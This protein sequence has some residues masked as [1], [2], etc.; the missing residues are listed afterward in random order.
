MQAD[1][2]LSEPPEKPKNTGVG[3][4]PLL[5]G[6]FPIQES[7]QGLQHCRWI[8]YQL[9]YQGS[10]HSRQR[11]QHIKG[12]MAERNMEP[13]RPS[14]ASGWCTEHEGREEVR[15]LRGCQGPRG[16]CHERAVIRDRHP[17]QPSSGQKKDGRTGDRGA[18][19]GSISVVPPGSAGQLGG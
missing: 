14:Q 15:V 8:L 4:L 12:P 6:I 5:Q 9:S 1:S 17:N 16:G 19:A 7:N 11:E 18:E 3:S 2:L 10:P 13:L